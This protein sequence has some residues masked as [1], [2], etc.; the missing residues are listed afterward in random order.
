M[1][2]A[3]LRLPCRLYVGSGAV[4]DRLN[5]NVSDVSV[6]CSDA[7]RAGMAL[8]GPRFIFEVSSPK[9]ARF[10][11]GRK[12]AEYLAIATLVAYAFIDRKRRSVTVCR[13]DR[14]PAD[15]RLRHSSAWRRSHAR[16]GR[17]FQLAAPVARSPERRHAHRVQASARN[18]VCFGVRVAEAARSRTV[19]DVHGSW[20]RME[21]LD[22]RKAPPRSPRERLDS[23]LMMPRTIDKIRATLAGGDL[24]EY[25]IAGA[26]QELLDL[27]GVREEDLRSAV[28]AAGSDGDV[29]AWLRE[30]A[31]TGKYAEVT[32]RFEAEKIGN[33]PDRSAFERRYPVARTL[34]DDTPLMD[35]LERDDAAAFG[36]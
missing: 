8:R 15:I 17:T 35:V 9:T 6:S 31:Q 34:P 26:S 12:V 7:D 22:L 36:T 14:G 3:T 21:P 5:A 30:H 1:L 32:E 27:I 33:L 11:T 28:A 24:G 2:S 10:D 13:P 18:W 19:D 16:R 4:V 20:N 23:L 25:K 29:A